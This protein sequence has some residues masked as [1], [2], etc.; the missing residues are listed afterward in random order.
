MS[1]TGIII[2]YNSKAKVVGQRIIRWGWSCVTLVFALALYNFWVRGA[3]YPGAWYVNS[4]LNT[5]GLSSSCTGFQLVTL[6]GFFLYLLAIALVFLSFVLL[7][8]SSI[9]MNS[10]MIRLPNTSKR[11]LNGR[12]ER[13]WSDVDNVTIQDIT[14]S[15]I[16]YLVICFKSGGKTS[17]DLRLIDHSQLETLLLSIETRATE[18]TKS[19]AFEAL[20]DCVHDE[21]ITKGQISFTDIWEKDINCRFSSVVFTPLAPGHALQD[22]KYKIVRQLS[23]GGFSAVYLASKG[24]DR[25]ILK[26]AAMPKGTNIAAQ[27]RA[28]MMLRKE[29]ALLLGLSHPQIVR[30]LDYFVENGKSYLAL[31][32]LPGDNLRQIVRKQGPI[33]EDVVLNWAQQLAG[34]LNYLHG[35]KPPIVHRDISPDNIMMQETGELFL[36]DFGAA[37]EFLSVATGTIVGKQAYIPPEQFKGKA[38][39]QSDIYGFGATLHFLLTGKDPEPLSESHPKEEDATI[40]DWMDQ[41]VAA[42]TSLDTNSR[43]KSAPSLLAKIQMEATPQSTAKI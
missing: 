18:A 40:S 6:A 32:Y 23:F 25:V 4:I 15:P 3:D 27:E 24:V 28:E 17:L 35:H 16:G 19:S 11:A 9:T 43:L 12:C 22:N 34:I 7:F 38:T 41:L 29:A 36:I 26:E 10:D 21:K 30:V 5:L 37:N 31:D 42:C 2:S 1:S 8:G 33:K 20:L 13:L 39:P 14:N